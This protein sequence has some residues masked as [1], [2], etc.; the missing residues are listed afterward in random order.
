MITRNKNKG[1]FTAI[2]TSF[3]R[4]PKMELEEIGLFA[5][6]LSR[7]DNW[8]FNEFV[9]ARDL[10]VP[11]SRIRSILE[12]LEKKGYT[13]ERKGKRG[14]V[15]DLFETPNAHRSAPSEEAA[16]LIRTMAFKSA[17]RV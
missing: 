6:M 17:I 15:W 8:E 10:A 12:S 9:L 3:L 7:P 13:K 1:M 11:A 14:V 2:S 16:E 5:V 4:D